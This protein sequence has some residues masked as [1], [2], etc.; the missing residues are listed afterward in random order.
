VESEW[1]TLDVDHRVA[2]A[3]AGSDTAA[4]VSEDWVGVVELRGLLLRWRQS[5]YGTLDSRLLQKHCLDPLVRMHDSARCACVGHA[6]RSLPARSFGASHLHPGE[7]QLWAHR[8]RCPR[9]ACCRTG[10]LA[11]RPP[12]CEGK[13]CRLDNPASG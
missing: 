2:R 4:F 5:V 9:V 10:G 3:R 6:W 13:P 11:G 8:L 12:R 7:H 1:K